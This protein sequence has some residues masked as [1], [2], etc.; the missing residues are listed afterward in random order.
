MTTKPLCQDTES[1]VYEYLDGE[2]GRFRRWRIRRHLRKCPPCSDGFQFEAK[3]KEKIR[4]ANVDEVPEE[5]WNHISTFLRQ[6]SE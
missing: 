5:L 3:L 4:S 1:K 6:N 2:I